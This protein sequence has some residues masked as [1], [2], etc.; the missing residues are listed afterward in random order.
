MESYCRPFPETCIR[1]VDFNHWFISQICLLTRS[2]KS[3]A[4]SF[5]IWLVLWYRRCESTF[6]DC[7]SRVFRKPRSLY[8]ENLLLHNAKIIPICRDACLSC[9]N[10][11]VGREIAI[12]SRISSRSFP[13]Q[14]VMVWVWFNW[15]ATFSVGARESFA[16]HWNCLTSRP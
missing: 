1:L 7:L 2:P 3:L 12:S 16:V 11:L 14:S 9:R 6:C 13:K 8:G 15:R 4:L 5:A 10:N